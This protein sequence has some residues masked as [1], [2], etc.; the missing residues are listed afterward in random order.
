LLLRNFF[1]EEVEI[2]RQTANSHFQNLKNKKNYTELRKRVNLRARGLPYTLRNSLLQAKSS[3]Y[4]PHSKEPNP[5]QAEQGRA[6]MQ[7]RE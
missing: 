4:S 3:F 6:Q 5:Q 2:L 7:Q 1:F